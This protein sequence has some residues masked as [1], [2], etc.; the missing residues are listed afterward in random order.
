MSSAARTCLV[1]SLLVLASLAVGQEKCALCDKAILKGKGVSATI[2][3]AEKRYRCVHCALTAVKGAKD[4]V[5]IRA[6][7]P[8]D[9]KSITLT[10][11]AGAWSQKP[12]S[13]VF[14]ILP[15]RANECLDV[16]QPF[17][18]KNEFDRYLKAHPEI[19]KLKPK[20]YTIAQYEQL[21][22]AGKAI[23]K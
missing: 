22:E 15:E 1:L 20:A 8:L 23:R 9:W 14:L 12:K 3:K 13:T 4:A 7:T 10:R 2:A 5:T 21:L 6:K 11:K 19:A 17:A 16:H 18:S